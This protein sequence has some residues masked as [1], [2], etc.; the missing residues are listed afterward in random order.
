M[1]AC[2]VDSHEGGAEQGEEAYFLKPIQGVSGGSGGQ[3]LHILASAVQCRFLGPPICYEGVGLV[4][5]LLS[6]PAG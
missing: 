5:L 1:H 2:V 4:C 6:W 3:P